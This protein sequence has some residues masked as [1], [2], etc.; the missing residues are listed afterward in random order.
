MCKSKNIQ[1]I[2]TNESDS[3]E[4]NLFINTLK[5]SNSTKEWLETINVNKK[6][7]LQI[8]LDSGAQCNVISIEVKTKNSIIQ[9][10]STKISAFG[11]SRLQVVG[12]TNLLCKFNKRHKAIVEFIIVSCNEAYV[13]T[14]IGLPTLIELNLI[15][16]IESIQQATRNKTYYMNIK[17]YLVGHIKGYE[18]DIKLK[19]NYIPKIHPCR[20]YQLL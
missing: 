12:K 16:R 13:P 18:Y 10:T 8:K 3:E 5:C 20:N 2:E 15:K 1:T 14:V 19:N 11:G 7:E 9:K 6:L 17:M 4:E